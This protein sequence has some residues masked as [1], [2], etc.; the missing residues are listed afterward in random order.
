MQGDGRTYR[1]PLILNLNQELT[2]QILSELLEVSTA[3]TN[4]FNV[5]NRVIL[6]LSQPTHSVSILN[7]KYLTPERLDL[8]QSAD[9]IWNSSLK[10]S[11]D[12]TSIWQAPLVIVPMSVNDT[13]TESLILRP[14][15]SKEAMTAD[16]YL[17]SVST[18]QSTVDNL[19][20]LPVSGI[21]YDLTHKPPG[22]IE[23][24]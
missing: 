4:Q 19:K 1:H 3:L 13:D 5:I 11:G 20:K 17:L 23:W 7:D 16:V 12:Y 15:S 8:L 6:S 10:Q 24:E 21:F 2:D 14:I 9:A 18:L 22:T